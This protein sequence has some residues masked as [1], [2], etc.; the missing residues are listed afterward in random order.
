MTSMQDVISELDSG[1]M[2]QLK[3]LFAA[4][5]TEGGRESEREGGPFGDRN[6]HCV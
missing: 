4:L 5:L 2:V 1:S 6:G 3:D